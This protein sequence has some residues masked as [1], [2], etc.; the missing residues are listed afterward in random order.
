MHEC[1][2]GPVAEVAAT[3]LL[4]LLLRKE[5]TH[6]PAHEPTVHILNQI[7]RELN[8][9]TAAAASQV[10]DTFRVS[11]VDRHRLH[12]I[13][14]TLFGGRPGEQARESHAVTYRDVY[15]LVE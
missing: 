5:V 2:E 10:T 14:T 8:E 3:D 9:I 4:C 12:A 1:D 6:L 15:P 7:T 13:E 11:F